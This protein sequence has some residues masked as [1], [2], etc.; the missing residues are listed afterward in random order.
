MGS[1][2]RSTSLLALLRQ[3]KVSPVQASLGPKSMT[4]LSKVWPCDLSMVMAQQSPSCRWSQLVG[5]LQKKQR[6]IH[7]EDTTSHGEKKRKR[8]KSEK[9]RRGAECGYRT[10]ELWLD[11][12]MVSPPTLQRHELGKSIHATFLYPTSFLPADTRYLVQNM[13]LVLVST[14]L[15]PWSWLTQQSYPQAV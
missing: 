13:Y 2:I 8:K 4:A 9:K 7:T 3:T 1:T 10:R 6:N 14:Y 5:V 12:L 11:G 15:V